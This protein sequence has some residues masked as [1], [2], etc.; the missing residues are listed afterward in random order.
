MKNLRSDIMLAL[1]VGVVLFVAS[2]VGIPAFSQQEPAVVGPPRSLE[3]VTVM[4]SVRLRANT[5]HGLD[6]EIS[7]AKATGF[8]ADY[9]NCDIVTLWNV[10]AEYE[11]WEGSPRAIGKIEV[12]VAGNR[13]E[14]KLR[15]VGVYPLAF[16]LACVDIVGLAPGEHPIIF[17]LPLEAHVPPVMI[18][19]SPEIR[20]GTPL[21]DEKKRIVSVFVPTGDLG[22]PPFISARDLARFLDL[23]S[24]VPRGEAIASLSL[25]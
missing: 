7:I 22:D 2:T 13:Y 14:G 10:M 24:H 20:P 23:A 11:A 21:L 5:R 1:T 6:R 9:G 18:C 16:N 4:V 12:F 17:P 25:K 3:V 19:L 8:T 15:H